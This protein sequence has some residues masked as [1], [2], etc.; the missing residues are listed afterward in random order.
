MVRDRDTSVRLLWYKRQRGDRNGGIGCSELVV[1]SSTTAGGN[2][3]GSGTAGTSRGTSSLSG[4]TGGPGWLDGITKEGTAQHSHNL[5]LWE[6][7][8]SCEPL[9]LNTRHQGC[10]CYNNIIILS[11]R[12][13]FVRN[14]NKTV[15]VLAKLND[16]I[17]QVSAGSQTKGKLFLGELVVLC[18]QFP[19]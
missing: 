6:V 10:N 19:R 5:N 13:V 9:N 15:G 4:K 14:R 1:N 16:V 2:S 3:G 12:L 7:P 11:T 18:P 17:P 8:L